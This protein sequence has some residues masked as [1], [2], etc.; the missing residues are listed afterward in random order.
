[1]RPQRGTSKAPVG[2]R[3]PAGKPLRPWQALHPHRHALNG[4]I[5]ADGTYGQ[6]SFDDINPFVTLLV[7]GGD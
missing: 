3:R 7:G 4:D 1:V 6:W 2:L 5:N